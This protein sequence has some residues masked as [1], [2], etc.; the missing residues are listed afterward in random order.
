MRT[1]NL[2][3]AAQLRRP[4]LCLAGELLRRM[5]RAGYDPDVAKTL[6]LALMMPERLGPT[7]PQLRAAFAIFDI[8]G[9]GEAAPASQVWATLRRLLPEGAADVGAELAADDGAG[10]E[11]PMLYDDFRRMC[12]RFREELRRTALPLAPAP[13]PVVGRVTVPAAEPRRGRRNR[14][15]DA[16]RAA[17]RSLRSG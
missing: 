4:E 15:A 2:V 12:A 11:L 14:A 6:A 10:D 5:E 17:R 7:E 8:E 16:R 1:F 3:L 9:L 13:A